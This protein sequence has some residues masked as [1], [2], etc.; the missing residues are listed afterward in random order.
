MFDSAQNF[1]RLTWAND[2]KNRLKIQ[3]A[4]KLLQIHLEECMF[5]NGIML[6]YYA[7][8]IMICSP[9]LDQKKKQEYLL[10]TIMTAKAAEYE[11]LCIVVLFEYGVGLRCHQKT[12]QTIISIRL[13]I[14]IIFRSVK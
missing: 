5:P 2:Q 7:T 1:S 12:G 10:H 8:M 13:C 4:K 11:I 9:R 3:T 6:N 14:T